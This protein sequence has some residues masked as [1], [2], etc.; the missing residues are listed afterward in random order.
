MFKFSPATSAHQLK[1][2][3][4]YTPITGF[5]VGTVKKDDRVD[6]LKKRG[7]ILL[8]FEFEDEALARRMTG[9]KKRGFSCM[10]VPHARLRE[11][12]SERAKRKKLLA[13]AR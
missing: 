5:S 13:K 10:D 1:T 6:P 3:Q 4:I 2:P 12:E 11:L 9:M 8:F 7:I